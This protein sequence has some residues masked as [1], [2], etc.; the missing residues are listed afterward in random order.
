MPTTGW[1]R[2]TADAN[3]GLKPGEGM[4]NVGMSQGS[5]PQGYSSGGLGNGMGMNPA[6]IVMA[7]FASEHGMLDNQGNPM[8]GPPTGVDRGLFDPKDGFISEGGGGLFFKNT[9]GGPSIAP[10]AQFTPHQS[11]ASASNPNPNSAGAGIA[12][13]SNPNPWSAGV[14][15][16]SASNPNPNSAG[17][18]PPIQPPSQGSPQD[19]GGYSTEANRVAAA[20]ADGSYGGAIQPPGPTPT[21]SSWQQYQ[22][23]GPTQ[24]PA[25]PTGTSWQQYQRGA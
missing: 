17:A 6:R 19:L 7:G 20:Q 3:W 13:K 24:Q 25:V 23:S 4:Q 9:L 2:G 14:G 10:E 21:G 18:G 22:N 12:S 16:A 15:M 5:G 8:V 11:T 1:A